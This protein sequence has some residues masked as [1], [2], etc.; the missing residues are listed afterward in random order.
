MK[1]LWI[2]DAKSLIELI[3]AD[4]WS[5]E[6]PTGWKIL[7]QACWGVTMYWPNE[8]F[9]YDTLISPIKFEFKFNRF[10]SILDQNRLYVDGS[11]HFTPSFAVIRRYTVFFC[12][13]RQFQST[14]EPKPN[15]FDD[16]CLRKWECV[17]P[18]AVRQLFIWLWRRDKKVHRVRWIMS[19]KNIR[20]VL[21][22]N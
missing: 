20:Q 3:L 22:R 13:S 18:A 19:R 7:K 6:L 9:I 15:E 8:K 11:T 5:L 21:V 2:K 17:N 10:D 14:I 4:L 12:F 16:D 1:I